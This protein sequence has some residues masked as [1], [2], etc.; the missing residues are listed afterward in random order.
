MDFSPT[1]TFCYSEL[2]S[3]LSGGY[4][5]GKN[6]PTEILAVNSSG[7]SPLTLCVPHSKELYLPSS[8]GVYE[9]PEDPPGSILDQMLVE[10]LELKWYM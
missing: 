10:L 3:N 1:N 6:V 4:L 7:K 9:P 8:R 2:V 5:E